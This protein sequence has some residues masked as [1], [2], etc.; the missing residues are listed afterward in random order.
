M[1]DHL[2]CHSNLNR[3]DV[4]RAVT[5]NLLLILLI[6]LHLKKMLS[7]VLSVEYEVSKIR[8]SCISTFYKSHVTP[9]LIICI[10]IL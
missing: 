2:I 5:V 8:I 7:I 4:S 10:G 9:L 3:V 6:E 1:K